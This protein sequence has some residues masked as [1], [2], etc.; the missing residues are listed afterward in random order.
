MRRTLVAI[1]AG[2]CSS[3]LIVVGSVIL[4]Y[5]DNTVA[6]AIHSAA[7]YPGTAFSAPFDYDTCPLFKQLFGWN[8]PGGEYAQTLLVAFLAW[9]IVFT[10]VA[11]PFFATLKRLLSAVIALF[12]TFV[13]LVVY[14]LV[15]MPWFPFPTPSSPWIKLILAIVG[16][17]IAM[18]LFRRWRSWPAVLFLV[19]SIPV[20][21]VNIS[22]VGWLW[23][24]QSTEGPNPREDSA[25]LVLLFPSDNEHSPMNT[26]LRY[27]FYLSD[28]CLP[29]AFF[30]CLLRVIDRRIA[31]A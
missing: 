31:N 29:I 19:A 15:F 17:L 3:A 11:Y 14:W 7:T 26:I 21:L 1:L 22:M 30:W 4:D 24:M 20:V 9:A 28:V 6:R 8:G 25:L 13:A 23:R 27:L 5:L 10:V 12:G 2:V 18:Y 16:L